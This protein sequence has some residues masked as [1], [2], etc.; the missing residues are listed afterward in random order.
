MI[1]NNDRICR[2]RFGFMTW[3]HHALMD[4]TTSTFFFSLFIYVFRSVPVNSVLAGRVFPFL[5]N[6]FFFPLSTTHGGKGINISFL[7]F[8]TFLSVWCW[9]GCV[10][11]NHRSVSTRNSPWFLRWRLRSEDSDTAGLKTKPVGH[12]RTHIRAVKIT[13]C[14]EDDS[15]EASL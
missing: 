2:T 4:L 14:S 9:V 1:F 12:E 13:C 11:S 5:K 7:S 3:R 8:F 10:K 15:V 6:L